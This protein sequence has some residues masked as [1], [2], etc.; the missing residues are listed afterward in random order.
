MDRKISEAEGEISLTCNE[1]YV[2]DD[3]DA[4]IDLATKLGNS[5][6]NRT[7]RG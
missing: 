2:N 1:N 4:F 6:Q 5:D 3:Y 7:H